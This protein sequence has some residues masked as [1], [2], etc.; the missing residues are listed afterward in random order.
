[1]PWSVDRQSWVS[2]PRVEDSRAAS[3]RSPS[4]TG[5]ADDLHGQAVMQRTSSNQPLMEIAEAQGAVPV[6]KN[7]HLASEVL[8]ELRPGTSIRL[9]STATL[10]DGT[11]R[12]C[13]AL[14]DVSL[15]WL[16]TATAD[17][18]PL[19]HRYARPIYTVVSSSVKVRKYADLSSKFV[20]KLSLGTKLHI[21]EM[22]RNEEGATRACVVVL[23]RAKT[24]SERPLGWITATKSGDGKVGGALKELTDVDGPSG[25]PQLRCCSPA[26][27][28]AFSTQRVAVPANPLKSRPTS[29]SP[30][31]SRD[32]TVGFF[33][34]AV[35]GVTTAMESATSSSA[36]GVGD[37]MSRA[38]SSN[39]SP[40]RRS[41]SPFRQQQ[42]PSPASGDGVGLGASSSSADVIDVSDAAAT[43]AAATNG[44]EDVIGVE[45]QKK[46]NKAAAAEEQ[47]QKKAS[48]AAAA[49]LPSP[50]LAAF[51]AILL[52]AAEDEEGKALAKSFRTLPVRLGEHLQEMNVADPT[53]AWMENLAMK[54]DPNRDGTVWHQCQRPNSSMP[55]HMR[56]HSPTLLS[57][58]RRSRRWS[59]DKPSGRS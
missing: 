4:P 49:M 14:S 55:T 31:P 41:P 52:K 12:A 3:S 33:G 20:A 16:T 30:S 29:R 28:E 27:N 53:G 24:S 32:S 58:S 25:S 45:E 39:L 18:M 22:K 54:W 13:V 17:G 35:L 11:K 38:G 23:G 8:T 6:T 15:G 40:K 21:V 43:D 5:L 19:V 7:L 10:N 44:A 48:A 9:L 46:R 34:S 2:T 59:G 37:S 42:S 56:D 1:M 51:V 57:F 26:Y 47:K 36:S 50:E